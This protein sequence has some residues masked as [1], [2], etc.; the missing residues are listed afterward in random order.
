MRVRADSAWA[1]SGVYYGLAFFPVKRAHERGI[2]SLIANTHK[3]N[4]GVFSAIY[5]SMKRYLVTL[6]Q[7]S[8]DLELIVLYCCQ[9]SIDF[10]RETWYL[11]SR[12]Y[13]FHVIRTDDTKY[14]SWLCLQFP[15]CLFE[16]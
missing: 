2:Y 8:A 7:D 10:S 15:G 4:S 12:D 13:E 11:D 14:M 3:V 9:H 6:A 1:H 5:T 16:F